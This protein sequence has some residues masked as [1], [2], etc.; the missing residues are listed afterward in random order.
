MANDDE[1][2]L[3]FECGGV[4]LE[5]SGDHAFVQRMYRRI[6]ED[7]EEA[8]RNVE[9]RRHRPEVP[10]PQPGKRRSVWLHRCQQMMHKVYMLRDQ[11]LDETPLAELVDVEELANMYVDAEAFDQVLGELEGNDTLW[12]EFT[13]SGRKKLKE[14]EEL[15]GPMQEALTLE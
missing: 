6:M 7:I 10:T 9:D 12:A 13:R 14:I 11:E 4:Q 1:I 3:R 8:R 5:I 2:S 15:T